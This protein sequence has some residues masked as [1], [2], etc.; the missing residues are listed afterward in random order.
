MLTK[1]RVRV[2]AVLGLCAVGGPFPTLLNST[3]LLNM[4][5]S[6]DV[7]NQWGGLVDQANGVDEINPYLAVS[8]LPHWT[9]F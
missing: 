3:S 9:L 4:L 1:K 5:P 6:S 7:A 2:G 8:P